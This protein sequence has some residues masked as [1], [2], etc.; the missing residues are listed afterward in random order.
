MIDTVISD[1][2]QVLLHFDNSLFLRRMMAYTARPVEVIRAVTHHNTELLGLFDKGMISPEEFHARAA[3][4]L[5]A[6]IGFDE[7]YAAYNDVFTINGPALD[8]VRRLKPG[9]KLAL[10]S[11]CDVMRYSYIE[12]RFPE[13]RF[14]DAYVLSFRLGVMKPDPRIYWEALRLTGSRPENTLFIDDIRANVEGAERLGIKGV[15]Y[16]PGT[17]LGAELAKFGLGA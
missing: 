11:N 4:A 2:G 15:L 8:A 14:F 9:A 6:R 1:L 17:D 13:L 10:L 12:R 16:A 3:A 5:D 7:F